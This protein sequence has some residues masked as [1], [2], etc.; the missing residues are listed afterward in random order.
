MV[1][2][3]AWKFDRFE[4]KF[5]KCLVFARFSQC[6]CYLIIQRR[7]IL[8]SIFILNF[9]IFIDYLT[10]FD[11][12]D[13]FDR[14]Y[15]VFLPF[16]SA[17]DIFLIFYRNLFQKSLDYKQILHWSGLF[18]HFSIIYFYWIYLILIKKMPQIMHRFN[19]KYFITIF[20]FY[21]NWKVN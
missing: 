11:W 13:Q 19:S 9:L 12:F 8:F 5:C 2:F 16:C 7:P 14:F 21:F 18:F 6:V 17:I 1:A 20:S 15:L 10:R 4:S 3:A